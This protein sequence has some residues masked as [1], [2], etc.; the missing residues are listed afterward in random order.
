MDGNGRWAKLRG[1][2]RVEGHRQGMKAVKTCILSCL[3][4]KIP[5]LTLYAFSL[6]NWERPFRE[7][8]FLMKLLQTY[9]RRER[10]FFHKKGVRVRVIGD[11]EKLPTIVRR[12]LQEVINLTR[13]NTKLELQLALSYG[14][15]NEILRAVERLV[16][17][18]ESGKSA[19]EV[20]TE[21][22]FSSFLDTADLPD[23]DLVIRTSGEHR[24]SNFLLWQIA[25]SEL[26]F[27]ERLW[28]EFDRIELEKAIQSFG[29]RSRRFGKVEFSQDLSS[30]TG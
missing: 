5:Y 2:P 25:Y 30:Q 1:L 16:D 7:V 4:L 8:R 13:D 6:E 15:R 19:K 17:A 29:A 22:Y 28:P 20:L 3:D 26:Y 14:G 9:A 12:E 23:P 18:R 24:V 11:F 27:T 10:D 21:E